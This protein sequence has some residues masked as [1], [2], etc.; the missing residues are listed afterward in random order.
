VNQNIEYLGEEEAAFKEEGKIKN[1]SDQVYEPQS[2]YRL[3]PH[4]PKISI[5]A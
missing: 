3:I 1:F 4:G 2:H 5:I